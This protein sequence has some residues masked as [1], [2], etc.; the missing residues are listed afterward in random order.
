MMFSQQIT[1]RKYPNAAIPRLYFHIKLMA[2][3]VLDSLGYKNTFCGCRCDAL[4][5][6]VHTRATA[7]L[8][9]RPPI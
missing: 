2:G 1:H 9:L 7:L 3:C 4:L 8:T 6:H 5:E